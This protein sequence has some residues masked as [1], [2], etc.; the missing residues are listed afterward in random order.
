[1]D[2]YD[3]KIMADVPGELVADAYKIALYFA[4]RGVKEWKLGPIQRRTDLG[5][6]Y[7]HRA[8]GT[9]VIEVPPGKDP[10]DIDPVKGG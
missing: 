6:I 4:E 9:V 5:G 1:M 10:R 7:S 8:P 3:K 2:S